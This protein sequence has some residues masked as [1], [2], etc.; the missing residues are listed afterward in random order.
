MIQK[1]YL[2][3]IIE[4]FNKQVN[5]TLKDA[6]VVRSE[7]GIRATEEA[8][9]ELLELDAATVLA[10]TPESFLTMVQLSGTGDVVGDYLAYALDGLADAYLLQLNGSMSEEQR[11][12]VRAVAKL[13]RAQ[14]RAVALAF[15][16]DR[17]GV[18]EPFRELDREV[19]RARS[20]AGAR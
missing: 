1:D 8:V 18:P 20:E 15:G 13:R 5:V 6:L 7:E 16:I 4:S 10:L 19:Q 11:A 3:K 14:A 9:G 17:S 2:S 12:E